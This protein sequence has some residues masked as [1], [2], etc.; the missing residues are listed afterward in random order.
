VPNE[1]LASLQDV[2]RRA[3]ENRVTGPAAAIEQRFRDSTDVIAVLCDCSGSMTDVVGSR[4]SKFEHLQIV[5]ADL[6]K[7]YPKMRIVAFG[8]IAKQVQDAKHL[9]NPHK[10][11]AFGGG[12]NLAAAL[13]L[14][15]KWR[16]RK[17]IVVSDGLPDSE[18]E[19][20]E[21][22][23]LMTGAIDTIYCGP[24][25]HPAVEFLSSLSRKTGGTGVIWNGPREIR[26]M[27]RALLPAPE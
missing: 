24:D 19:A 13:D 10:G 2:I 8:S 15:G 14:A 5:L 11:M 22:A 3:A 16:P 21:A 20:L 12:T 1:V 25:D 9:P 23:A 7:G 26:S 6:E 27:I 17:T 18:E 4:L